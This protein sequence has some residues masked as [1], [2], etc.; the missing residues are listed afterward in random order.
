MGAAALTTSAGSSQ[1]ILPGKRVLADTYGKSAAVKAEMQKATDFILFGIQE[2][3]SGVVR[4]D[5]DLEE[6]GA[7]AE[8]SQL[9]RGSSLL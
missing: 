2:I 1:N 3:V 9:S 8:A 6:R 4:L 7:D 5:V